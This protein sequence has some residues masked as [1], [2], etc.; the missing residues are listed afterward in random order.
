M[1]RH[2]RAHGASVPTKR[3]G[4]GSSRR[5]RSRGKNTYRAKQN[6][7]PADGATKQQATTA[8][9]PEAAE[10][11]ASQGRQQV[12]VLALGKVVR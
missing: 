8:E 1:P 12:G 5:T 9:A 7:R 2:D 6:R 10:A 11:Q 3:S 4:G